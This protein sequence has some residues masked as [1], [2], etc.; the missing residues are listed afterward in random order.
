[1]QQE[2][3]VAGWPSIDRADDQRLAQS[4]YAGDATALPEIYDLF[5]PW[6][7]DYSHV[8][9]RDQEGAALAL[10]DAL[11]T[12]QERIS[13]LPDAR[14]FRGWLYS[15]TRHECLRRRAYADLPMGRQR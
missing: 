3:L 15:V 9:L 12:V 4:L 5:A 7:F 8:L 10:H 2:D 11:I 13:R 6:L 14:L 1:M